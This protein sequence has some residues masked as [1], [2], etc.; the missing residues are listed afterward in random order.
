MEVQVWNANPN[1]RED[2]GRAAV[3]RGPIT[4]CLEEA[5]NG[6]DL[7]LLTLD[8]NAPAQVRNFTVCGE[9]VKEILVQGFKEDK[10]KE[11]PGRLYRPIQA[12][13]KSPV[14][15]H[16]IPYYTWANR[17]ENEMSVWVRV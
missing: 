13:E 3:T 11:A 4:Y 8:W 16:F 1:V 5:D 7:H 17:G 14:T 15:L 6:C 9:P 12:T 2:I 10:E